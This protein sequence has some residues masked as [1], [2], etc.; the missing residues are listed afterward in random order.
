MRLQAL[1]A[2]AGCVVTLAA[3]APAVL[4][5]E[6][7]PPPPPAPPTEQQ[8]AAPEAPK[9]KKPFKFGLFLEAGLGISSADALNSSLQTSSDSNAKSSVELTELEQARAAVGW[10]LANDKGAFRIL[11]QGFKEKDYEYN[12]LGLQGQLP[13][14]QGGQNPRFQTNLE[15]WRQDIVDG[16]LTSTRLFPTWQPCSDYDNPVPCDGNDTDKDRVV[17]PGE[18]VYD[19]NLAI[20]LNRDVADTLQNRTQTVDLS[21]G[22]EFGGR[23]LFFGQWWGGFRYFAYD[24]N[25]LSS[26]WLNTA[27]AGEGFTDGSLV[28]LINFSQ[29]TTGFGPSGSIEFG[30][31]FFNRHFT[32]FVSGQAAFMVLDIQA[33]SG[34]FF[35]LVSTGEITLPIPARLEETRSKSSWQNQFELGV[36]LAFLRETL[37]IELGYGVTTYLDAVLLPTAIQIPE[38]LVEAGQGSSAVYTTQDLSFTGWRVMTSFQF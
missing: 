36:R 37:K 6:A 13:A 5:Q 16:E 20:T 26:A 7:P 32:P 38:T 8:V 11:F 31:S 10:R 23:K 12:S 1:F 2:T 14:G 15:W 27:S 30:W 28:R 29:E 9:P 24:G 17:D 4:A 3:V 34:E 18:V 22:R 19:A 35:T 21:Y 25:M 33:D